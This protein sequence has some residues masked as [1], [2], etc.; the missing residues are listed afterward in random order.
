MYSGGE[1]ENSFAKLSFHNFG[2]RV[3]QELFKIFLV[4][5][6]R[7]CAYFGIASKN[8][9]DTFLIVISSFFYSM[10]YLLQSSSLN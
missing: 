10:M 8:I 2:G 3:L 9:E 4:L 7:F 5:W 1:D 6:N